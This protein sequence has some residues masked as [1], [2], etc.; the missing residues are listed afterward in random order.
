[1][2]F[3]SKKEDPQKRIEVDRI[4]TKLMKIPELLVQNKFGTDRIGQLQTYI[5]NY[6]IRQVLEE[7][8]RDLKGIAQ[9][10]LNATQKMLVKLTVLTV[11]SIVYSNTFR[12]Y[13]AS[14]GAFAWPLAIIGGFVASVLVDYL[15]TEAF[16]RY[17]CRQITRQALN[18]LEVQKHQ[19]LNQGANQ[20]GKGYWDHQIKFIHDIE[21]VILASS[22]EINCLG[23]NISIYIVFTLLLNVVEFI[24]ASYLVKKLGLFDDLSLP[25]E[26]VISSLPVVLTWMSAFTQADWFHRPKYA[27]ELLIKYREKA[28]GMIDE[29]IDEIHKVLIR[30]EAGIKAML[31]RQSEFPTVELAEISADI[32]YQE[33]QIEEMK[34][35][36]TV[37]VQ[38]IK[39]KF[40]M[41]KEEMEADYPEF[42]EDSQELTLAEIE[43][44]R[45]S[46]EAEK[47]RSLAS[48][49]KEIDNKQKEAI[50]EYINNL[51]SEI[52]ELEIKRNISM[53]KFNQK[54]DEFQKVR[55]VS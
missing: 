52:E 27:H 26:L 35:R 20:F 29:P 9:T 53:K 30:L 24:G 46:Y 33:A 25:I 36:G 18:K 11:G 49:R 13:T 5:N 40:E 38:S 37:K 2:S 22:F 32:Q 1:M 8:L 15:A 6:A 17:L 47:N 45:Q 34:E 16:S 42:Q 44:F 23:Y 10:S 14:F 48:H 19:D 31:N 41:Q 55:R 50:D 7:R 4:L 51:Q 3:L 28:E 21:G 43:R 12:I 54:N 39:S